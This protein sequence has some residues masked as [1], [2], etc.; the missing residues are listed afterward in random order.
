MVVVQYDYPQA[1]QR[2]YYDKVFDLKVKE[3]S[4]NAQEES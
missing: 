1:Y 2:E 4:D 3:V